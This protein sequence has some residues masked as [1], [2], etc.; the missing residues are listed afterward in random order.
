MVVKKPSTKLNLKEF[1]K[2]VGVVG[3]GV[4][5]ADAKALEANL[6]VATDFV[7]PLALVNTL[8][9]PQ[10]IRSCLRFLDLFRADCL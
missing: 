5:M 1:G 6:G 7:S 3:G 10:A 4:R 8:V 2:V 9:S